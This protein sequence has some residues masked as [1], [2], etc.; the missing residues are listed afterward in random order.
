[1]P[2]IAAKERINTKAQEGAPIRRA[3]FP[4]DRIKLIVYPPIVICPSF[5]PMIEAWNAFVNIQFRYSGAIP[6]RAGDMILFA[7]LVW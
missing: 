7:E 1:M 2:G 4:A 6:M 5:P 3:R